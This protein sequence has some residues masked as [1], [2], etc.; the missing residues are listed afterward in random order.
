MSQLHE[1][2]FAA[3]LHVTI[4]PVG[5]FQQSYWV[6][7]DKDATSL[8][9][10]DDKYSKLAGYEGPVMTSSAI[11]ARFQETLYQAARE[12]AGL[13]QGSLFTVAG[14]PVDCLECVTLLKDH[15]E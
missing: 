3:Q 10:L 1:W 8:A 12:S 7:W 2:L 4:S 9:A 6:I 13:P 15:E 5:D 14:V 11:G